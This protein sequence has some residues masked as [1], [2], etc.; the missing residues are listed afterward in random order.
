VLRG[1]YV[2]VLA[3]A[4][5]KPGISDREVMHIAEASERTI[6][7]HDSDYGELIFKHGYKPKA[8][9]IYFRLFDFEP[10]DPG[11]ILL[12][13]INQKHNFASVL[14]LINDGFVKQR[15]Y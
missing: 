3:I 15:S 14:T 8:G 12:N 2:D 1:N 6:L 4:E 5:Y 7:T 9:V 13:L 10:T 11:N